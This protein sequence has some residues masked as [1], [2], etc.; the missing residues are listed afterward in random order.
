MGNL[1]ELHVR[2]RFRP[3]FTF[4][5]LTALL[6]ALAMLPQAQG[7][8]TTAVPH[9]SVVVVDVVGAIGVGTAFFLDRALAEARR[10]EARLLIVRL[11]TPGGLVSATR[12]IVQHILA[13][14]IPVA[15][16]VAPSGARAASAGTY[17]TYAA[18]FA[19]M[20][21]G[22]HIG[23]ATPIEIGPISQP[24]EEKKST[25]QNTAK[26]NK[27]INDAVAYIRTLAELRGRDTEWAEKAVRQAATITAAEAL[28]HNVVD[29]LASDLGELIRLLDGRD[30]SD[31]NGAKRELNIK[32]A[33]VVPMEAGWRTQFLTI[34]TDPNIAFV[35]LMIG[36][37]GIVFE[38]WSPG[39][40]GPG[41]VG[42]ISLI[43]A[44]MALS[45]L[46]INY[47]GVALLALGVT[48]LIGE[49]VSPGWGILGLGGLAA[50]SL[51]AAFLFDPSGADI[52]FTVAWPVILATT[53]T[54]AVLLVGLLGLVVRSQKRRVVSGP[55]EI[56]G[57]V[58]QV[59][60]WAVQP[61]QPDEGR[62]TV[63]GENWQARS[64]S[65]LTPGQTVK[66]VARRGLLLFVA[67]VE[68]P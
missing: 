39:L 59:T 31:A 8:R 3:L 4:A 38:F 13:S 34:I 23:A 44:L 66:V 61:D 21:P 32:N 48:L 19:A 68:R 51:G 2:Y 57:M 29:A 63:N 62:V 7:Q 65:S 64:A 41:V 35:L 49:A 36:I 54:S 16:Y 60:S 5:S 27:L 55:E 20:A 24:R 56:I 46:P 14:Q 10:L 9:G 43:V 37:Y 33:I 53:M 52:D 15:V 26:E 67:P 17:L 30:Y 12:D 58:G 18:H 40:T 1:R 6:G 45:M 11:D 28:R 22:T 25:D 42:G 47:A 50:L